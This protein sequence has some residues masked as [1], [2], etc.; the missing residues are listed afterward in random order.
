MPP[1]RALQTLRGRILAASLLL[2]LLI[3]IAF[4]VLIVSVRDA[5]EAARV[6]EQSERVAAAANL[7]ERYLLDLETGQRAYVITG[8]R[9]FLEP[10]DNALRRY[11][12][13]ARELRGLVV[14]RAQQRRVDRIS[15]DM[16]EYVARWSQPVVDAVAVDRAA[17]AR[18]VATGEGK[19]RVD[20]LRR[21]FDTFLTRQRELSQERTDHADHSERRAVV[22]GLGGLAISVLLVF[23][24]ASYLVR[25]TI[26]PVEDVT[27]AARRLRE[28][29]RA[30]R[31][32][33]RTGTDEASALTRDFN[34]MAD[35]LAVSLDEIARRG[36][37]LEAVLDSA[38][39]G[40]T[41]T[42]LEGRLVFSNDRME[43]LWVELG[44]TS[45]G[46]VW[47]RLV[48][49][50]Q[51]TPDPAS[52]GPAFAALAAD[53]EA[54]LE[55]DFDVPSLLRSFH[56]YTA[57][58]RGP[59]GSVIGRLFAL[60]E[61]TRE[62]EA[63]RAKEQFLAT[64]SHE[65]RTPLTSILGFTE[66][67]RDGAAGEVTLEQRRFLDVVDRNARHLNA[68]VDDLLLVGR[69]GEG[70]L[71]LETAD[72]DLAELARSALEAAEA[73]AAEKRVA[74]ELE[75]AAPVVLDADARRLMQ[76][77][78]NLIG[79]AIKFTPSGGRV[80]VRVGATAGTARLAVEDSGPG[81]SAADQEHLFER[82]Y[83]AANAAGARIPG[84]GLGLAIVKAIVD[85][86]GGS[87]SVRSAP[88]EGTT[89]TAELPGVEV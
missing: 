1:M 76:L 83:R 39:E 67:V 31:A 11:P 53:P 25:S 7:L 75:A 40:I 38:V 68:L 41:M 26:E 56:G 35:T 33:E 73:A 52:Y 81:I 13:A 30:A 2:A 32:R 87:I 70:R 69:A 64:V 45:G 16:D 48:R 5:R 21:E 80:A 23:L 27:G 71:E 44:M 19:R 89:F 72:V 15:A 79:N 84:T 12:A 9:S 46:T 78:H 6:A 51:L 36:S 8:R 65:L 4:V 66:L 34:T 20:R 85:A 58:V 24:F 10:W 29:D 50:A 28:G 17:A 86:H 77:L 74:L 37:E 55:D 18:R 49:L 14:D 82:F 60:G 62:R 59:D 61:T 3:G 54:V 57:P 42:D 88:G 63:D 47:E 43:S 22:F